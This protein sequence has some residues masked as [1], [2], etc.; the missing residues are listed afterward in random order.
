MHIE[1][2]FGKSDHEYLGC[3]CM[4]TYRGIRCDPLTRPFLLV[5]GRGGGALGTNGSMWL[6]AF[7]I[8]MLG[9]LKDNQ[10]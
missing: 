2:E 9:T 1:K 6:I 3:E 5:K 10:F 7:L 8:C 4:C